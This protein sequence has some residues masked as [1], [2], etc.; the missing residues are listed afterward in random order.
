MKFVPLSDSEI[1]IMRIYFAVCKTVQTLDTY[2]IIK[3]QGRGFCPFAIVTLNINI[4]CLCAV[5]WDIVV[6]KSV[7]ILIICQ[8][9][10]SDKLYI[11]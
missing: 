5:S 11:W 10:A 9:I 7:I 2:I 1:T 3:K 8:Y 6:H 4:M